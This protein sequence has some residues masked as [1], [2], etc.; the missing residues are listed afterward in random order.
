MNTRRALV[1]RVVSRYA[2]KVAS[3]TDKMRAAY[4]AGKK[5][6][7]SDPKDAPEEIQR[8]V[9]DFQEAASKFEGHQEGFLGPPIG[10]FGDMANAAEAVAFWGGVLSR[11]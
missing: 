10:L 3:G 1:A 2:D 11:K 8:A 6:E 4:L 9:R 7:N 5:D